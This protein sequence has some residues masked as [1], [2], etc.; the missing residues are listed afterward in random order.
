MMVQVLANHHLPLVFTINSMTFV[1][2]A[3]DPI[4]AF[5]DPSIHFGYFSTLRTAAAKQTNVDFT[6]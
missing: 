3:A 1:A 2:L 5:D 4:I 6:M